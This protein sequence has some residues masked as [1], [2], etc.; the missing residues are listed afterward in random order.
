MGVRIVYVVEGRIEQPYSC[1]RCGAEATA[2]VRV[3]GTADAGLNERRE[4]V[5]SALALARLALDAT[6]CPSCAERGPSW[7]REWT[8][9]AVLGASA[10]LLGTLAWVVTSDPRA[11]PDRPMT[12]LE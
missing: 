9:A 11:T 12:Q 4:A 7:R 8:K 3:E 5:A 10:A 2:R 1:A 6:P